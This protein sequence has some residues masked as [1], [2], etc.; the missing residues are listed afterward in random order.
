MRGEVGMSSEQERWIDAFLDYLLVQRN[1]SHHTIQAYR[2]DLNQLHAFLEERS[3]AF[4]QHGWDGVDAEVLRVYQHHLSEH[5]YA[6]ATIAR[7][8]ATIRSLFQYLLSMGVIQRDPTRGLEGP[9][10]RRPL[11]KAISPEQ[12]DRLLEAPTQVEGPK[13]LRDQA[14]LELL[15][16]TGMRVSELTAL[17][18]EDVDLERNVVRCR[19]KGNKE[20]EVPFHETAAQKLLAYLKDGRPQLQNGRH[21]NNYLFLNLRGRPLTRQGIWLIIRE[22]AKIAGIGVRVTPHVLRHSVATHLLRQ[23]A[24]LREVQEL[25][26]HTNLTTT[27]QYTRV[28]NEHLREVFEDTHPRA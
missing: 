17:Q 19:G 10:V 1:Y 21:P 16:A 8:L 11:P 9:K 25:L 15:Y 22:Y 4:R 24:N 26:G 28:V 20:R 23:G 13:G 14:I 27:Q 12:V 3:P 7:K 18:L 6:N 2:T 5:G